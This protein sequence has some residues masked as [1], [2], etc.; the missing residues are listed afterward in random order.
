MVAIAA[1]VQL[2]CS[3]SAS[4]LALGREAVRLLRADGMVW[5]MADALPWVAWHEGRNADAARLQAWSDQ[6]VRQRKDQRSHFFEAFRTDLTRTLAADGEAARWQAQIE[7]PPELDTEQAIDLV[8][9][10]RTADPA[11]AP[12]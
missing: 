12:R 7:A 11:V 1:C 3:G 10:E 8:L 9:G 6:L 5:W 4:A 2:R